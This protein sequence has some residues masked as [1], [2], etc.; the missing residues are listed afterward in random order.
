MTEPTHDVERLLYTTE[1]AATALGVGVTK[2]KDLI[3]SKAVRSIKVGSLRRI[4][5][6]ALKEY[7][8]VRQLE[9]AVGVEE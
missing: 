9:M 7:I 1:E 3:A 8:Q 5:V 2:M 6:S 4:P